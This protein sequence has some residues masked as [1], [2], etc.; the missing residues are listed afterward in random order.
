MRLYNNNIVCQTNAFSSG[1][2]SGHFR[3]CSGES[4]RETEHEFKWLAAAAA[5][6]HMTENDQLIAG[7]EITGQKPVKRFQCHLIYT[8]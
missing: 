1:S 2:G 7:T 5:A 4:E 8:L 3:C 6:D